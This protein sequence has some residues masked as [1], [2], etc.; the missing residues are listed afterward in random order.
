M[1]ATNNWPCRKCGEPRHDGVTCDYA[2]GWRACTVAIE[3]KF[4]EFG[5]TNS[6]KAICDFGNWLY[7]MLARASVTP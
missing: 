1:D 4:D 5:S 7:E 3:K 6:P 2:K